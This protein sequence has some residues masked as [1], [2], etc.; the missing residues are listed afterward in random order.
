MKRTIFVS[1]ITFIVLS[2]GVALPSVILAASRSFSQHAIETTSTYFRPLT[3]DTVDMEG[4]GDKDIV[5]GDQYYDDILWYNNNGSQSFTKT[6]IDSN[7]NYPEKVMAVDFDKNG[8]MDVVA[9]GNGGTYWYSNNGSQVFTKTSLGNPNSG[10]SQF[11]VVDLDKDNDLDFV[12][13]SYSSRYIYWLENNG[14][15][16]FTSHTIVTDYYYPWGICTGDFDGDTEIDIAVTGVQWNRVSWFKNDGS[17]GFSWF[18]IDSNFRNSDYIVCEDLD[19][20]GSID[21]IA[22]SRIGD[23]VVWYNNDGGGLFARG[24]VGASGGTQT[25][26]VGDVDDDGDMDVTAV[27]DA[28]NTIWWYDNDGGESF[29]R[30]TVNAS[31]NSPYSVAIVDLDKDGN[32]D[33]IAGSSNGGQGG[34]DRLEWFESLG[35]DETAPSVQNLSPANNSTGVSPGTSLSIYFDENV[36]AQTGNIYIKEYNN[37]STTQT[38]DVTSGQVLGSGS[39]TI[40]ITTGVTLDSLAK[41]YVLLDASCFDDESGNSFPGITDKDTWVFTVRDTDPPVLNSTV[42]INSATAVGLD[43]NL[44]FNFSENVVTGSGNI[45]IKEYVTESD[46][47]TIIVGSEQV[48]GSGTAQIT[49]NPTNDLHSENKYYVTVDTTAF[50]DTSGNSYAGI[51]DKDEFA[52]TT[53]DVIDPA[54]DSKYP[55]SSAV[56]VNPTI[57]L[58]M[59]FSELVV[60]Q[61][62]NISIIDAET[63]IAAQTIDV[64]SSNVT[65]SGSATI[66][67]DPSQDLESGQQ[68]YILVDATAFDDDSGNSFEG[69]GSAS[70]WSFTV[71]DVEPPTIVGKTP[72]DNATS[73]AIGANLQINFSEAVIVGSGNISIY[74]QTD[75]ALVSSIAAN[76][77]Y[78]SGAGTATIV[79]DL[80][81]NLENQTGYFVTVANDCFFDL[82]ANNFVGISGATTWNFLTVAATSDDP[83]VN[84]VYTLDSEVDDIQ[85]STSEILRT[86]K[87]RVVRGGEPLAGVVV[88]LHSSI[89][90]AITDVLGYVVFNNVS[91][92]THQLYIFVDGAKIEKKVEV[93]PV[94]ANL[95][96]DLPTEQDV[97]E[98]QLTVDIDGDQEVVELEELLVSDV[99]PKENADNSI[100]LLAISAVAIAGGVMLIRSRR[101]DD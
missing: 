87:L 65:G 17:E 88:E 11:D 96:S 83:V 63:D 9:M 42:P 34:T 101:S 44:I 43:T 47:E 49:V 57:N 21:I 85:E 51:S 69:I 53:A 82:A 35:P 70:T 23:G 50:D 90:R 68:Y 31:F 92:G 46:V 24:T 4:D 98:I 12:A 14:S 94:D 15:M 66:T 10:Y 33:I 26:A 61:T 84:A 58:V 40:S 36:I 22:G 25:V 3:I 80:P 30:R 100:W 76:S 62:G 81:M 19:G 32:T 91:P 79:V 48:T 13:T 71:A 77:G 93:S 67:I 2:L 8:T 95:L 1:L 7:M 75:N 27:D 5:V 45:V 37:D 97:A 6:T 16:G 73:V 86:L 52:F 55:A 72:A 74:Q 28:A 78:V 89:L 20:S 39:S 60:V 41:Y 38:I 64:T 59:N 18:D 29:T 99:A 56:D 54:L